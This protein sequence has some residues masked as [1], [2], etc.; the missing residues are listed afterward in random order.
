LKCLLTTPDKTEKPAIK[1]G[2]FFA[3]QH[4][5]LTLPA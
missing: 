1:C 3:R 2:L 4:A 5:N